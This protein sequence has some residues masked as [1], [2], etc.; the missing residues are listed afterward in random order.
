MQKKMAKSDES[1]DELDRESSQL[2]MGGFTTKEA[3]EEKYKLRMQRRK[4]IQSKRIEERNLEKGL[5]IVFTGQGKGK[6]TAALGMALRT[7]G[8]GDNV[9]IVQFIKGGWQPGEAKALKVYGDSLD[10]HAFGEGFT[11]ETQDRMQDKKLSQKAWEQALLYLC[12]R[13]HKL[14]ILDEIN[15]AI[16]LGYLSLNEVI[17]GIKKRPALTHVVLTGR[18]AKEEL[19]QQA[20]LVTEMNLLKHPFREKGVKAQKGIEF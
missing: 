15:I 19:I 1:L 18:S 12:S 20:D 10:W 3:D 2:G 14:V 16:K 6:T 17:E 4:E 5:I 8:H 11:W 13:S 9:A 7:L